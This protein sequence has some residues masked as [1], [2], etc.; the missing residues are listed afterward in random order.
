VTSVQHTA[1]LLSPGKGLAVMLAYALVAVSVAS[2][3]MA[4]RDA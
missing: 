1:G 2:R 4:A 3:L